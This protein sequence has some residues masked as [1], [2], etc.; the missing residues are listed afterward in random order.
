MTHGRSRHHRSI[1][2]D[3]VK[4][5]QPTACMASPHDTEK[6]PSSST[7][8][9]S[10]NAE[11]DELFTYKI[12]EDHKIVQQFFHADWGANIIIVNK[13]DYFTEF[14]SCEESLNPI[15]GVPI[16]GIKGYGTIIFRIRHTLV[17]VKEIA[18]MPDNPHCTFTTSHLQRLNGFLPGI[19]SMHSSVKIVNREE[20][21]V[22]ITS[23]LLL[24]FPLKL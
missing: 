20:K 7:P 16:S 24:Y 15:N 5:L 13:K 2:V 8:N 19:H 18:F 14:T 6:P 3:Y 11:Q 12:L 10:T 21:M 17:P 9:P 1:P 4:Y 22:L 23:T